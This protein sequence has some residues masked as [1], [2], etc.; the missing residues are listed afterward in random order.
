MKK[1]YTISPEIREIS[2]SAKP[3]N[4]ALFFGSVFFFMINLFAAIA[5]FPAYSLSIGSSPFLSGLQNTIFGLAAVAIRFYLAPIMDRRGAKPLMLLGAFTF[6]TTPLLLFLSP[7]YS[8]LLTARIYQSIGLAVFLPGMYT[9]VAEMAPQQRIGTFVGALRVFFNLG[10]LAGP[11][12]G[13]YLTSSYGYESWF[14]FT[15]AAG[16]ASFALLSLTRTPAATPHPADG[17]TSLDKIRE[18]LAPVE[19]KIII[20]CIALFTLTY[21]AVVSFSAIHIET[22]TPQTDA[23]IF[24]V[25]LGAAGMIS[26]LVA[27]NLTDHFGRRRVAIP[28]LA[29]VG[30][31][32]LLFYFLPYW[33]PLLYICAAL[34][35]IGVQ[36]ISLVF[37]AWLLDISQPHLRATTISF[38]EN[39]IDIMFAMG[40]LIFGLAAQGPGLGSAFLAAGII[41]LL[42][43]IPFS[44]KS[45]SFK[46][47]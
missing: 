24:F 28:M 27:G 8:M 15:I 40:A 38:Q 30:T 39:S 16:L 21:S 6:A 41:T 5:I 23:S 7:T 34:F 43:V 10:L 36:G 1:D 45:A 29:L 19:V 18:A 32:A 33:P 44:L 26:C 25:I 2:F 3:L 46:R 37:A 20:A 42:A 31:G 9:V 4:W 17:K 13:L 47:A 11:S 35:G 14:L 12:I 22:S